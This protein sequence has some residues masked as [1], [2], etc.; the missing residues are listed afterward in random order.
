[1]IVN[2]TFYN[3]QNVEQYTCFVQHMEI[4][5]QNTQITSFI[6]H[7]MNRQENDGPRRLDDDDV[8]VLQILKGD[9][10]FVPK[11][12]AQIF[13]NLTTLIAT[14]TKIRRI[15]REDLVGLEHLERLQIDSGKIR[16]L[17]S[18]LF[19]GMRKLKQINFY[20]NEIEFMRSDLLLPLSYINVEVINFRGNYNID[21]IYKEGCSEGIQTLTELMQKIDE[22][23]FPPSDEVHSQNLADFGFKGLLETGKYSNF[24]IIVYFDCVV[25]EFKVH[26]SILGPQS[27]VFE[28]MFEVNMEERLTHT[29]TIK[30][31]PVEVVKELLQFSYNREIPSVEN[32]MD[33]FALSALYDF[34]Q[35][36]SLC[37]DTILFHIEPANAIEVLF[38]GCLHNSEKLKKRALTDVQK[39]LPGRELNHFLEL[40]KEKLPK[41]D[42]MKLRKNE[43]FEIM[44][45]KDEVLRLAHERTEAEED[46]VR[47]MVHLREEK[48]EED[49]Q[50]EL[51]NMSG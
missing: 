36:K 40:F 8:K 45:L 24:T 14:G 38:L 27:S 21:A 46:F 10:N 2:C 7:H 28:A 26:K 34:H 12:I 23:C 39:L 33:L 15:T 37:E 18:N 16:S 41:E 9:V 51:E 50:N 25:T 32:A 22:N 13:P 6:G 17:P 43:P 5:Q 20:S 44:E 11:G 31:F 1:M 49:R 4:K 42:K 29:L 48:L 35:L 19:Q 30:D 3:G 47:F